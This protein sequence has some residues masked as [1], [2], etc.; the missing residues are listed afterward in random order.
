MLWRL[1]EQLQK[2]RQFC[3]AVR[4]EFACID[5]LPQK[6][7]LAA[8]NGVAM[9]N[10]PHKRVTPILLFLA[11]L[12]VYLPAASQ[13]AQ[14]D[15]YGALRFNMIQDGQKMTAKDFDQWLT[16]NNVNI[17]SGPSYA[18]RR[19]PMEIT[20]ATYK[21]RMVPIQNGTN[22]YMDNR[23]LVGYDSAWGPEHE[24]GATHQSSAAGRATILSYDSGRDN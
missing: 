11:G 10:F 7:K 9:S 4:S 24:G 15:K 14:K 2:I 13:E 21:S 18:I 23:P 16:S 17:P 1:F 6:V 5:K 22:R 20:P 19:T 3:F 12:S 8:L